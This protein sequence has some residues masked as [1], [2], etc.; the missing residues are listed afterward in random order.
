MLCN[1]WLKFSVIYKDSNIVQL[2]R[3]FLTNSLNNRVFKNVS[4]LLFYI[5][6]YEIHCVKCLAYL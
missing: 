3:I 4:F 6:L 1:E 2:Y 5:F